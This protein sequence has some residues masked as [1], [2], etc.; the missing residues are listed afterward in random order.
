MTYYFRLLILSFLVFSYTPSV[1]DRAPVVIE[2]GSP[3]N[4]G[5][6][7]YEHNPWFWSYQGRPLLL[8]GGSDEDNLF[9]WTGTQLT[10]HLDLLVSVR[11][12]YVRNTMSDRDDGNVYAFRQNANGHYD[13]NQWNTAYWQHPDNFLQQTHER[14]IIVQL[15][16]WDGFDYIESDWHSHPWNPKNNVNYNAEESGLPVSWNARPSKEVHPL[17]QTVPGMDN[18]SKGGKTVLPYQKA[19]VQKV[20]DHALQYDHIIFN[21]QNESSVPGAWGDFWADF[22]HDYAAAKG[23]P[24]A[25]TDMRKMSGQGADYS[26]LARVINNPNRY[27]YYDSS[28]FYHLNNQKYYD[29][30][31]KLRHKIAAVKTR[32]INNVK[33]KSG[34][35]SAEAI[36]LLW[37]SVFAGAASARYHRPLD[38]GGPVGL[39]RAAQD[40][41]K[42]LGMA[43]GAVNF[44]R[45]VPSNHLLS[46]HSSDEAYLL[47]SSDL[48][49]LLYFTGTANGRVRLDL[50]GTSEEYVVRWLKVD[51]AQWVGEETFTGGRPI[52][53]DRPGSGQFVAAIRQKGLSLFLPIILVE[54]GK[55]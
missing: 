1:S 13:L 29:E 43:A 22:A 2:N 5:I 20:L 36:Q 17:N 28:Q 6:K 41:V 40:N 42:S 45:M 50:S 8:I 32:P 53:I 11:G 55:S 51:G 4:T 33:L 37:R 35:D 15:T 16:F 48:E 26:G 38:D 12:N 24:I 21:V 27:P 9:Q 46:D 10:D 47:G 44:F 49:Y 3:V 30:L 18:S 34:A 7:V 31:L 23:V 25:I 52:T 54:S 39:N 14:G 19:Y